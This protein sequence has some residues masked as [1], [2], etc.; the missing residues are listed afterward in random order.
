MAK[1]ERAKAEISRV[2]GSRIVEIVL[3]GPRYVPWEAVFRKMFYK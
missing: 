1:I 3:P 2:F